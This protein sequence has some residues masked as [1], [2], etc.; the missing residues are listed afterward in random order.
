[1]LS[2]QI[3]DSAGPPLLVQFKILP[4]VCGRVVEYLATNVQLL[5]FECLG[6]QVVMRV[7][8]QSMV[9]MPCRR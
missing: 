7:A 1:M 5:K 8:L 6:G 9:F 2:F 4:H 3:P